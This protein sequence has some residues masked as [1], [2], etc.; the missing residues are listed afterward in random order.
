MLEFPTM[1]INF[2]LALLHE[3]KVLLWLEYTVL[4]LLQSAQLKY[5][6]IYT[7]FTC[8]LHI[9]WW[10]KSLSAD[11]ES[12][13]GKRTI[14]QDGNDPHWKSCLQR[15]VS[16]IIFHEVEKAPLYLCRVRSKK[17]L[18]IQEGTSQL[19]SSFRH[20]VMK[21]THTVTKEDKKKNLKPNLGIPSVPPSLKCMHTYTSDSILWLTEGR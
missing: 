21:M 4:R 10:K 9:V 16:R 14:L 13:G 7:A 12:Q 1:G 15:W 20:P 17:D 6:V 3:K 8:R 2:W 5:S 19:S 18:Y 11:A